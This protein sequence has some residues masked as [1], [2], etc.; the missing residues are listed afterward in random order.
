MLI[1]GGQVVTYNAVDTCLLFSGVSW[2]GV[3]STRE[4]KKVIT[5]LSNLKQKNY[6]LIIK[7]HISWIFQSISI[8]VENNFDHLIMHFCGNGGLYSKGICQT[9]HRVSNTRY[10]GLNF[11]NNTRWHL[12][13]NNIV[14][15]L[16][17]LSLSFYKLRA[18]LPVD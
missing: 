10:L 2:D 14:M 5:N 6:Q 9:V 3:R 13:V 18:F 12:H 7:K 1:I 17:T 16:R 15:H 8:Y 11:D 4:L